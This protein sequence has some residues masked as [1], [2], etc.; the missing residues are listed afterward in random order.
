MTCKKSRELRYTAEKAPKMGSFKKWAIEKE[1]KKKPTTMFDKRKPKNVNDKARR[2]KCLA[3]NQKRS[4]EE[5][6]Y[7]S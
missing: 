5:I 7:S 2:T 1:G 6:N 4:I 3:S